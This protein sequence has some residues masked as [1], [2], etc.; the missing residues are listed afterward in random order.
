VDDVKHYGESSSVRVWAECN[1]ALREK[2]WVEA[3]AAKK[4]VEVHHFRIFIY[5]KVGNVIPTT[6]PQRDLNRVSRD[7]TP[8]C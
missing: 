4:K 8:V 1:F 3:K 6:Y 2:N 5:E 7:P